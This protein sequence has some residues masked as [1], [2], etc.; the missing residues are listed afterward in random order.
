MR[1]SEG[2]RL[3]RHLDAH[4]G[5]TSI[6]GVSESTAVVL[7]SEDDRTL[8]LVVDQVVT[9]LCGNSRGGTVPFCAL[10]LTSFGMLKRD[11]ATFAT[12]REAHLGKFSAASASHALVVLDDFS[13][14]GPDAVSSLHQAWEREHPLLRYD[15][16]TH[17]L[18]GFVFLTVFRGAE[19]ARR[20]RDVGWRRALEYAWQPA[21]GQKAHALT[22][23]AAAGTLSGGFVFEPFPSDWPLGVTV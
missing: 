17:D 10:R 16:K 21:E 4:L 9:G 15:G 5:A 14:A 22:P 13:A 2:S 23:E 18:S 7:F 3:G 6:L 20:A 8:S 19:H 1:G 12:R 11:L